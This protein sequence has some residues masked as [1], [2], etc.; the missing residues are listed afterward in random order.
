VLWPAWSRSWPSADE[1][2]HV[3]EACGTKRSISSVEI[4]LPGDDV[5]AIT[6]L[7]RA[8]RGSTRNHSVPGNSGTV[9]GAGSQ[10]GRC[11]IGGVY[12]RNCKNVPNFQVGQAR[13]R[14][15]DAPKLEGMYGLVELDIHADTVCLGHNFR[16]IAQTDRVCEVSP[17]HPDYPPITGMPI[18]QAATAYDDP[19]SG[20]TVILIVNQGIYLG[21]ALENSIL[22]PNQ[23][24][25]YG[26]IVDDIHKHLAP[27]PNKATHSM[28]MQGDDFR[29]PLLMDGVISA[30]HSRPPTS[31]K[32]E[33]CHWIVLTS[34]KEWN[35]NS[36]KFADGCESAI[37][38]SYQAQTILLTHQTAR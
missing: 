33:T 3:L 23:L 7:S 35:T 11:S 27:D 37:P 5:S 18:M 14:V 19:D 12:S 38:L 6:E 22:N 1:H 29:I 10:F 34:K 9:A 15:H 8:L 36:N 28:R 13:V 2:T 21:E 20:E 31:K 32:L 16:V 17:Y 24:R 4:S 25:A 26:I 30:F